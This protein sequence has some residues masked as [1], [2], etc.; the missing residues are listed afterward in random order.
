MIIVRYD[1]YTWSQYMVFITLK[2]DGEA[3]DRDMFVL[4]GRISKTKNKE[5][6]QDVKISYQN[7]C[8]KPRKNISYPRFIY[9]TAR[10]L[11]HVQ[12]VVNTYVKNENLHARIKTNV[13]KNISTQNTEITSR[14]S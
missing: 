10:T 13:Q 2:L 11:I 12:D 5:K 3:L 6:H 8:F 7:E 14:C 9:I 1:E 4:L